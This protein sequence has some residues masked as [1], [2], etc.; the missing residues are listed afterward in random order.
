L[1]AQ[2]NFQ[3]CDLFAAE[4]RQGDQICFKK[5][6]PAGSQVEKTSPLFVSAK[7]SSPLTPSI[8]KALVNRLT[9]EL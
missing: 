3:V 9:D 6:V 2:T 1:A 5:H 4:I 8:V 7:P